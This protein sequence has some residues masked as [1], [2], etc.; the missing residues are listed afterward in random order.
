MAVAVFI[1][2]RADLGP[3]GPVLTHLCAMG[4]EL[5][6]VVGV[7]FSADT[8]RSAL[9][10]NG[11]TTA[12]VQAIGPVLSADSVEVA[13]SIGADLSRGCA[14]ALDESVQ[15]LVVL[16]DRWELPWVVMPAVLAQV[17]V[18]HIHGG[19][20]TEGAIDERVRHAMTKL[21]DVH[22]VASADAYDRLVQMGEQPQAVH[23]TGAPGLDR[24]AAAVPLDDAALG[25]V[26]GQPVTHPL[27]L[28]TYHPVTTVE[29]EHTVAAAVAALR[30]TADELGQRGGS[31]LVTY[32]GPD[33][34]GVAMREALIEVSASYPWVAILPALG[35][36]YPG[37]LAA[38]DVVVGNSSSGVIEA[39]S[40]QV[41]TVDIGDRQKGRLRATSVVHVADGYET[42]RDA[43]AVVLDKPSGQDVVNPYGDGKSGLRIAQVIAQVTRPAQAKRFRDIECTKQGQGECQA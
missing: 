32:P 39:A 10:E 16:G 14:A 11:V 20:V 38:C 18:V 43:L 27:A 29:I 2:G 34:G 17:P 12:N 25:V 9:A 22:C 7:G 33:P 21:A 23:I 37:T 4:I 6:I 41:A 24:L 5:R 30:A 26:M 35:S 31:V 8:A 42:V 13:A 15:A 28:F 40:A 36:H 19:E 3:L 1:S